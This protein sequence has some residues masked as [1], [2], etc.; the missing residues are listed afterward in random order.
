MKSR[1]LIL[2]LLVV[3]LSSCANPFKY[4]PNDWVQVTEVKGDNP[5]KI[6]V[7]KNRIE[8]KDGKCSAWVKM[9]FDMEEAIKFQ[10]KKPGEVSGTMM[11]GR[12]DSSVDYDC[13]REV[14]LI[15]SYQLYDRS[16]KLI[17]SKW[18]QN[19]YEYAKE[20][21]IQGDILKF[22]CK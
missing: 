8:C 16:N 19:E 18:V 14:A 1:F 12:V 22:V 4:A 20:G 13:K 7:D 15:N 2:A 9:V 11:I 21:T 17:D 3:S 5:K 6:Y 10:G